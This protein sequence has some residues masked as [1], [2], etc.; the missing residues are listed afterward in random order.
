MHDYIF[1]ASNQNSSLE[2]PSSSPRKAESKMMQY[3]GSTA[4]M[5]SPPELRI[6]KLRNYRESIRRASVPGG[7]CR[8]AARFFPASCDAAAGEGAYHYWSSSNSASSSPASDASARYST[9]SL[10]FSSS[11]DLCFSGCLDGVDE[12][13]GIAQQMVND[14][15][16]RGLIREFAA[17]G[18]GVLGLGLGPGGP[19]ELLVRWFSELDVEWVLLTSREGDKLRPYLNMED[20][21]ALL[22]DLMERWIK[23]LKTMVQV[24]CFTQMEL[25]ANGPAV[26]VRKAIRYFMLLATGKMAEREQ[27]AA[28]FAWFAEGSVL[29]MLDFVDAVADAALDD[30][31]AAAEALPG[32][33]QVYTCVVDDSPAVLTLLK[34]S[35][36][37]NSMFD[38]MNGIFLRKRSKLS[39]AIW[40]MMEVVRASFSTN[41]CWRVSP[42]SAGGVHK[43]TKLVMNYVMLLWRNEGALNLVLQDQR[44]RFRMFPSEHHDYCPSSVAD[45]IKKM[46]SSSEKQLQKA[47]NFISDPGLRYIFLMNNFSFISEKF[48][49]LLL[50]SFEGYK[51]ERSRERLHPMEDC[52]KQPDPSIREKIETDS[53][54]DGLIKIESFLEAYLDASWEPVMS[55]LY[56][57]IP[58]GFLKC[59]GAMHKFELEIERTCAT[60]R[61]WKVPNP[62]L[63]KRLRKAIT[64]KVISGY[65]QYL[66][67]RSARG[68]SNRSPAMMSTSLELEELIEE[69]FE[70]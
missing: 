16:M 29:R 60:Q 30:D 64:E 40:G 19:E 4:S 54:L 69:L 7:L 41:D 21:C 49:T 9:V 61:M 58:R 2:T 50:P 8:S 56:H 39:D 42:A 65:N 36:V 24:L 31:Q 44:H 43:T 55:S 13:R 22:L 25:R 3:G 63:K 67:Q 52:V 57:D 38:D 47:S 66:T 46:I 68:K 6:Q 59:S 15:Y 35:S 45:L 23:A 48:S 12:L 20:G 11:D 70:G 17:A 37:T 34:E 28:Q 5:P 33:L 62:E 26:G 27:E 18:G 14:G 1:F 51:I 32:M 10:S 53:N